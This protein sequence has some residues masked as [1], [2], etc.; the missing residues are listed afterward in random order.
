MVVATVI[1]AKDQQQQYVYANKKKDSRY[2]SGFL[3]RWCAFSASNRF[4]L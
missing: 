3:Q 1:P 2:A 4:S